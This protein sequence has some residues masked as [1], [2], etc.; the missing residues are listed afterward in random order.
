MVPYPWEM[1]VGCVMVSDRDDQ[2]CRTVERTLT[3]HACLV[4][5]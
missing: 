2:A 5:C 1:V 3:A 4:L